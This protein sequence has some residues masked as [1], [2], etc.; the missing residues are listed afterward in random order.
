MNIENIS[1]RGFLKGIGAG[2]GSL[3]LSFSLP[4]VAK[5]SLAADTSTTHPEITAWLEITPQSQI[6]FTAPASEMGQGSQSALASLFA[7]ELGADY[8]QL[9]IKQP[10]NN[11]R[12]N[13]PAF[14]MQ[15]TGGSTAVRA[16]WK[17]MREVAA[18]ARHMLLLAAAKKQNVAI[19][20][21]SIDQGLVKHN[22][23]QQP[24]GD[25]VALAATMD[26]PKSITLKDKK[27]YRYIG[28]PM[29]R[30]DAKA[31]SLGT[32]EFG[33]DV[34]LPDMLV[35]TIIQSPI[36]GGTVDSMDEAAAK[37]VPGVKSVVTIEEGRSVAV[38]ANS[39]WQA[40]T[41]AKA[42]NPRFSGGDT[43]GLDTNALI[44][45]HRQALGEN[46]KVIK[47]EHT[48]KVNKPVAKQHQFE[49]IA[50]YLAHAT[51]EPMNTTAW[52]HDNGVEVWSPT[53]NQTGAAMVAANAALV[54]PDNVTVHTTFLGG[55]FG[56]RGSVDY[57]AQAVEIATHFDVPV[58]LIWS[59][60]QDM[61][62]DHYRPLAVA[63]FSVATAEDG[64]PVTFDMKI[65]ADS[66][67]ASL[68]Q[69]PDDAVDPSIYEG[70]HDQG[71][72]LPGAS[73]TAYRVAPKVPVSFW[74]SVGH[75]STAFFLESTLN[76]LAHQA[77]MDPL[78]YR[79]A[80]LPEQSRFAA[81]LEKVA[82]R[83]NWQGA[84]P[85]AHQGRGIAVVKSFGS[86]VAEVVDVSLD[87]NKQIRINKVYCVVDC[88][89]TANP[90]IV[91]RQMQGGI[92]M[93]LGAAL[94][95]RIDIKDG[96]VSQSNFHNY[97][98][99][100]MAHIPEI[101]VELVDS[102][103]A[104]GGYGE[105][106]TPPAMAALAGAIGALTGTHPVQMPFGM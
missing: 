26:V 70:L 38:V 58:K 71:Y 23:T 43:N 89:M 22:N 54:Q 66:A 51:M 50:P 68:M 100:S 34:V 25:F 91:T 16:W 30:L 47:V 35:A 45:L 15:I 55:G 24:M 21:I 96:A 20:K 44:D 41:G 101:V 82:K 74:R 31:K 7:D 85:G 88:G 99:L 72:T 13:N 2:S 63:Q 28:K 53:Q 59:R 67:I 83:A 52:V 93:G 19:D 8:Q 64:L 105:P 84:K 94:W 14:N 92:I 73:L 10:V 32:A 49:F 27:D 11:S 39:Y 3:V 36:F 106:G 69:L 33:M 29:P 6:M 42:L 18:T 97:R 75:S 80:L 1:R 98:L 60:E 104:P 95:S 56:R 102:E 103:E 86:Y 77:G 76:Q 65:A 4:L 5:R 40:L 62:H 17:P 78:A 9:I 79:Q 81:V 12:Y 61:Q 46:G 48:K 57:V 90:E 87:N 37:A